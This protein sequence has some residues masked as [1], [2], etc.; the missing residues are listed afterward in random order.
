[1]RSDA[2]AD[3]DAATTGDADAGAGA[4]QSIGFFSFFSYGRLTSR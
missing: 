4:L 2:D 3:A 1:V